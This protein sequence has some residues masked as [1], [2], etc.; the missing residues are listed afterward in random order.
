MAESAGALKSLIK[1]AT[2]NASEDLFFKGF[3]SV[4]GILFEG[5]L[6]IAL[7]NFAVMISFAD[8]LT[9][10]ARSSYKAYKEV[11]KTKTG[12]TTY[13]IHTTKGG[14]LVAENPS[15]ATL[16][17]LP[18][19]LP[20]KA[21]FPIREIIANS[22]QDGLFKD[23]SLR[24]LDS[25]EVFKS[26]SNMRREGERYRCNSCSRFI[27][28]SAGGAQIGHAAFCPKNPNRYAEWCDDCK[29]EIN[30]NGH[31][32]NCRRAMFENLRKPPKNQ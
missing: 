8:L 3:Q 30:V 25:K 20:E 12:G 29:R 6:R 1:I 9:I 18:I 10:L 24:Q 26:L 16:K 23:I 19:M 13:N 31:A 32:S 4:L 11:N 21:S 7:G 22:P 17:D 28:V 14:V 2:R 5:G 15:V 27:T